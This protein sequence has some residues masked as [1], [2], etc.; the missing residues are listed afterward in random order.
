MSKLIVNM[1][2]EFIIRAED[3]SISGDDNRAKKLW[4]LLAYL[5]YNRHRVVKQSE[6]IDILWSEYEKGANPSGALKTLLYRVRSLLDGLWNGAGK[7]LIICQSS[8]YM[9]NANYPV[10]LDYEEFNKLNEKISGSDEFI[11][12]DAMQLLRLYKGEF[13]QELSSEMWVMPIATYY[14]NVYIYTLLRALPVL[15][16]KCQYEDIIELC[17]KT[18][19]SEPYH[20]EIYCYYMRAYIAMDKQK[21]AIEIYQS[22]SDK[23]LSELG[24]IPSEET[25]SIY[26]EAL[27]SIN[28]HTLTIEMLHDQLQEKNAYPGAL[29]CDYDFFRVLYYSMVRSVMRYSIAVHLGLITISGKNDTE[30]TV[31]KR[32]KIM[33]NLGTA[34][35]NSVRRSDAGA[36]CSATQY[37]IMLPRANYEDSCMVCERIIKAYYNGFSRLDVNLRYEVFPI[38]LENG[39]NFNGEN[40]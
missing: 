21:E 16:E 10:M 4:L 24:V 13:L 36:R 23:L 34:I 27:K 11:L 5:I 37:I 30:L 9:W 28:D 2:G 3:Q 29:I 18:I 1:F 31:Q 7:Q 35:R 19:V 14:H 26:Y 32:E 17:Q 33:E 8:G 6:L 40:K 22:L 12:E 20:E 15:W 25:R 39:E 38:L